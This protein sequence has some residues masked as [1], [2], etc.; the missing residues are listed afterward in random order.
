MKR[1]DGKIQYRKK[2]PTL[3]FFFFP[4]KMKTTEKPKYDKLFKVADFIGANF[5]STAN[6]FNTLPISSNQFQVVDRN[7]KREWKKPTLGVKVSA[8][9][10]NSTNSNQAGVAVKKFEKKRE[11]SIKLLPHWK[12]VSE[13]ECKKMEGLEFQVDDVEEMYV[14]C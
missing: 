2:R 10:S 8:T 14:F 9:N 3:S 1:N 4:L 13:I 11:S 7:T 12:K 6:P 5:S